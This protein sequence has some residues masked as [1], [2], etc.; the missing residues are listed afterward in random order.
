LDILGTD[1]LKL[2]AD[3]GRPGRESRVEKVDHRCTFC[4]C[5]HFGGA[6]DFWFL[7]HSSSGGGIRTTIST[8]D[9]MYSV[10]RSPTCIAIVYNHAQRYHSSLYTCER[11]SSQKYLKSALRDYHSSHDLCA[12][13]VTTCSM[14]VEAVL[15]ATLFAFNS[16]KL[17]NINLFKTSSPKS[18]AQKMG[19]RKSIYL[20]V[21]DANQLCV[22]CILRC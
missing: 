1:S 2:R 20:R 19:V 6:I 17:F 21:A 5:I 16:G 3:G 15:I 22:T 7:H 4:H 18:T 9:Q 8:S 13:S 11:L 10:P 12:A 14:A